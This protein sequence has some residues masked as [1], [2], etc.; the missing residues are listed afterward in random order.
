MSG[1]PSMILL[2]NRIKNVRSF[3]EGK[4][5]NPL[6]C[7]V[8]AFSMPNSTNLSDQSSHLKAIVAHATDG[9]LTTNEEGKIELSIPQWCS[10]LATRRK[11]C[12]KSLTGTFVR[13][14]PAGFTGIFERSAQVSSLLQQGVEMIGHEKMALGFRYC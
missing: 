11:K 3:A 1:K 9:I 8:P 6:H 12:W 5:E 7:V 10:Y 14:L 4:L 13:E 2:A